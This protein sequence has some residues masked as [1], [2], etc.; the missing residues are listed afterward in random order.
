M[1]VGSLDLTGL[2]IWKGP[3]DTSGSLGRVM[4]EADMA[5]TEFTH[6]PLSMHIHTHTQRTVRVVV[7]DALLESN[8]IC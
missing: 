6:V 1:F 7:I 5:L 2:Q 8:T 4:A 3:A